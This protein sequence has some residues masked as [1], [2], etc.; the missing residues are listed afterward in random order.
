MNSA[1]I[2]ENAS[3]VEGVAVIGLDGRFPQAKNITEFLQNLSA[4]KESITFLSEEE[5]E[6]A[7]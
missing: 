6:I 5:R 7:G 4:G 1:D 3:A 2:D